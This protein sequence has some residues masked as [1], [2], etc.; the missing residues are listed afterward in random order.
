MQHLFV[1]IGKYFRS[2]K[3][4]FWFNKLSVVCAP[5]HSRSQ[6]SW[7]VGDVCCTSHCFTLAE[8]YCILRELLV[9]TKIQKP[10]GVTPLGTSCHDIYA[11]GS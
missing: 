2:S 9:I 7:I 5:V 1:G 4:L 3:K 8:Q 6:K 11:Y 10:L